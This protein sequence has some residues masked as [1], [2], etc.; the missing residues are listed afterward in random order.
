MLITSSPTFWSNGLSAATSRE[1]LPNILY[2]VVNKH[3]RF[4]DA[5]VYIETKDI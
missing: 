3:D 4:K 1:A 2:F 5:S